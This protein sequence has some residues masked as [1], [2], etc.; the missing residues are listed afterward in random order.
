MIA[1]AKNLR[2]KITLCKPF[3]LGLLSVVVAFRMRAKAVRFDF[4]KQRA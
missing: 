2:E 1:E 4:P 3:D